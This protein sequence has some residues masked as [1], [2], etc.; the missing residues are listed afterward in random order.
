[1][2]SR[3]RVLAESDRAALLEALRRC[4]DACVETHRR[5]GFDTDIYRRVTALQGAIDDVA[6][7]LTGDRKHFWLK[8]YGTPC[9]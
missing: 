9:R 6:E 8:P 5:A 1:M 3:R 7:V 4:R 2:V